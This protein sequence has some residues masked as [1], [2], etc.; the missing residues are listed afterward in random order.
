MPV[1]MEGKDGQ[2]WKH[3]VTVLKKIGNFSL[4]GH[5][6]VINN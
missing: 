5:D 1:Y 6:F 3:Y 2:P 4:Q